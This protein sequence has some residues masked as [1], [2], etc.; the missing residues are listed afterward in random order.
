MSDGFRMRPL[1]GSIP[2]Y[3]RPPLGV[4]TGIKVILKRWVLRIR[5][6]AEHKG[7]KRVMRDI[8]LAVIGLGVLHAFYLWITLPNISN[9]RNLIAAQSSVIVDRN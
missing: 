4:I 1:P 3:R 8:V 7:K 2:P 5:A 9:P 6:Y